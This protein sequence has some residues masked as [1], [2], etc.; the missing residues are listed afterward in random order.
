MRLIRIFVRTGISDFFVENF[1]W[2]QHIQQEQ[3]KYEA[4]SSLWKK[5]IMCVCL[6]AKYPVCIIWSKASYSLILLYAFLYFKWYRDL[7][8]VIWF[9]S[10]SFQKQFINIY[11][12]KV[13]TNNNTFY[14]LFFILLDNSYYFYQCILHYKHNT[15]HSFNQ[16]E[17]STTHFLYKQK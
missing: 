17:S 4:R 5:F 8:N 16:N 11:K 9:W 10:F 12:K 6:L 14:T 7:S 1:E 15:K 13:M 3:K 2:S